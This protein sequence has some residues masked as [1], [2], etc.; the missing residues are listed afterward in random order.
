[1]RTP[2]EFE[3]LQRICPES[4]EMPEA[5]IDYVF[6]PGLQISG[7]GQVDCLLCP[8]GR[9]G[10]ATRLFLAKQIPGK[11]NNW[12]SH[13]ILDRTWWTWS[14]KDVGVDLRLAEILAAHLCAL[15]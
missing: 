1:M 8:Q 3:E 7:Q 11:G 15:R 2:D 10:Y 13:R 5:N 6:L 14:W 12:T 9:D 4:K